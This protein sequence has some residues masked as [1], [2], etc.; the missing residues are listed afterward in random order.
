MNPIT[1]AAVNLLSKLKRTCPQ[2]GKEQSVPAKKMDRTVS[3]KFCGADIPA[4]KK[5]NR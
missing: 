2:C 5:P 1:I 3:C 4:R